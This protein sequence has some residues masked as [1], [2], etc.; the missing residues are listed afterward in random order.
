[1][2]SRHPETILRYC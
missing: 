2:A 1:M